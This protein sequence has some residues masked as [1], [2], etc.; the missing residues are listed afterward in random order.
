MKVKFCMCIFLCVLYAICCGCSN[1]EAT[2]NTFFS[3]SAVS[4]EKDTTNPTENTTKIQSTSEVY[5]GKSYIASPNYI[6]DS[7][8]DIN[9]TPSKG[10]YCYS[11]LTDEQKLYYEKLR[12]M[13]KELKKSFYWNYRSC[14]T[15]QID[16]LLTYITYDYPEYFWFSKENFYTETIN[17]K[18]V[19][20]V[21]LHYEYTREEVL[22][23]QAQLKP[24]ID[25]YLSS[26]SSLKTDYEKALH[27][28]EYIIDNTVYNQKNATAGY[29]TFAE[30]ESKQIIACWNI[31]GVFLNGDAICR[32]YTQAYQYLM[33]LQGIEC[34]YVYGDNH[35]WNL[36]KLDG[37]WYYTDITWGDPLLES[38]DSKTG[39][40]IYTETGI[41]YRYFNMT[42]QQLL[43][44]HTPDPYF[45]L[46]LPVCTATKD[47]YFVKNNIQIPE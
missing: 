43:Q 41:D 16:Q 6:K 5:E 19:F 24:V 22:E 36:T 27:A 31:T 12:L 39:E 17:N 21:I 9:N 15:Q 14:N 4:S 25:R 35:C 47:N 29:T 33:N 32:G 18:L 28:Y 44:I 23:L 7:Y 26:A 1:T 30:M 34:A 40:K 20:R 37:D 10:R 3:T 11:Q 38:V 8:V 42:T 13:I 45:K 46:S 2:Q